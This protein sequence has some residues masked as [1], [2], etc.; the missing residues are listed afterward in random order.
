MPE[1]LKLSKFG[2]KHSIRYSLSAR[3]YLELRS[4]RV[5][6]IMQK[7]Q[8]EG[9]FDPSNAEPRCACVLV[10]DTSGSMEGDPIE[11]LNAGLQQF[12]AEVAR[13]PVAL[14]RVEVAVVTFGPVHLTQ[15]FAPTDMC[16]VEH[17]TANGS[18][19]LGAALN[20]ALDVL[21]QRKSLY[22][23]S[24]IPYYRPWIFLITDGF[25]DDDDPWQAAAQRIKALEAKK[26]LSFFA[27]GVD[28]A[29]MDVLNSLGSRPAMRL[30]GYSFA[31]MFLW[32]SDSMRSVSN[33]DPSGTG[34]LPKITWGQL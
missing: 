22:K 29:D 18:T 8:F 30:K 24:G 3:Q 28:E 17:L 25:P 1:Y 19:P 33:S 31:E 2:A 23:K 11:Q 15:A 32:L 21:E 16:A 7:P 10:L 34:P 5:Q 27:V 26:G 14:S 9:I 12:Y 4:R 20:T 6:K 13:D